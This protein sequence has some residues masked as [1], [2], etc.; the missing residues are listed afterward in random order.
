MTSSSC[1]DLAASSNSGIVARVKSDLTP[2]VPSSPKRGGGT[3]WHPST[4]PTRRGDGTLS[5]SAS[6][7]RLNSSIKSKSYLNS[8]W[9]KM[10]KDLECGLKGR[11]RQQ[12]HKM[13]YNKERTFSIHEDV[14]LAGDPMLEKHLTLVDAKEL[15]WQLR[16]EGCVGFSISGKPSS[17]RIMKIHFFSRWKTEKRARWYSY[18]IVEG[19]QNK[20]ISK[21][22]S[23]LNDRIALMS[24]EKAVPKQDDIDVKRLR[25]EG[26]ADSSMSRLSQAMGEVETKR[27][28]LR[29]AEKERLEALR[30]RRKTAS[31]SPDQPPPVDLDDLRTA[32]QDA[33][34]ACQVV[35]Q[36][37]CEGSGGPGRLLQ[38]SVIKGGRK[39]APA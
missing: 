10:V 4:K 14:A 17:W 31:V 27:Q 1:G 5:A 36:Q 24:M 11:G 25:V 23:E 28:E 19:R 7:S 35:Y 29:S 15:C 30:A 13:R 20:L 18:G 26:R 34:R 9:R 12:P 3:P 16:D 21:I 33:E 39:I 38:G 8:D 2:T 6:D 37:V 32:L 22:R